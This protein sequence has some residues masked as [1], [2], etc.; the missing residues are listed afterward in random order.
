M[1]LGSKISKLLMALR[2]KGYIFMLHK[3]QNW[4]SKL[5]R[6]STIYKLFRLVPVEEYN[7]TYPDKKRDPDKYEYVKVEV[8]KSFKQVDVLLKLAELY[9]EA[10][11]EG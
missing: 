3:E 6:V 1:K 2:Q 5:N 10:G 9:K 7:K 4:S 11:E 8:Y